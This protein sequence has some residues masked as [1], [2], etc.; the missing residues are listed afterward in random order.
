MTLNAS[1]GTFMSLT[2]LAKLETQVLEVRAALVLLLPCF[3]IQLFASDLI[4]LLRYQQLE[5][6]NGQIW[7][8]FTANF[9]HSNWYH[10][11]LNILGFVVINYFYQ[12]LMTIRLRAYLMLFCMVLNVI[13]LHWLENLSWYV[14]L[15]GALHGFLIGG[16]LLTFAE[17]KL[18]NALIIVIVAGKLYAEMVFEI[19][20]T[21]SK[22]IE[23]NVVEEAHLY[24]AISAVIFYLGYTLIRQLTRSQKK[25]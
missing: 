18:I 17:D 19:N 23:S 9:C 3:V 14:G 20:F 12:P 2:V 15:S 22:L 1:N 16:A 10:W 11:M 4:E 6:S 8:I 21:A 13:L 24:G 25:G 7:R 5:V